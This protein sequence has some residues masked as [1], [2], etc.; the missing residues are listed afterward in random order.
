MPSNQL[1]G[2]PKKGGDETLEPIATRTELLASIEDAYDL[3]GP[4]PVP[5]PPIVTN[6][7]VIS[8]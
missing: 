4:L 3:D 7:I 2:Q 8:S 5:H 6:L 1:S